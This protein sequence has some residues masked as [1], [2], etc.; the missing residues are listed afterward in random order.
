M[1]CHRTTADVEGKKCGHSSILYLAM[2]YNF[3]TMFYIAL[4][5]LSQQVNNTRPMTHLVF[6][7]PPLNQPQD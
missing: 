5:I 1:K 6:L 7:K 4:E 2:F 3:I